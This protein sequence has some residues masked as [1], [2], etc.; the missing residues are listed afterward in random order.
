MTLN[1]PRVS[2][3]LSLLLIFALGLAACNNQSQ[4]AAEPT[5]IVPAATTANQAVPTTVV[6]E[7]VEQETGVQETEEGTEGA[8]DASAIGVEGNAVSTD[9][10]SGD[11]LVITG[12]ELITGVEVL[13]NVEVVTDVVVLQRN[14]VTTVVTNTDVIT[15]VTRL[16]DRTVVTDS[17]LVT[18][19]EALQPVTQT[20]GIVG[21]VNVVQLT[22]TPTA[23][24]T[25][26]PTVLVAI[27]AVVT[28]TV[29]AT[30]VVTQTVV[31]TAVVTDTIQH[32]VTPTP[33][34]V[35]TTTPGT[36]R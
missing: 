26:T 18:Q 34:V 10:L 33:S 21:D 17:T 23:Q 31:A 30:A 27:T 3:W 22:S 35:V 5:V 14:L 24:P 25:A 28:D 29:R 7:T 12:T 1:R 11:V 4:P 19:T 15:D 16:T 8:T 2:L 6:L 9:T 36:G 32:A 20:E 13:T